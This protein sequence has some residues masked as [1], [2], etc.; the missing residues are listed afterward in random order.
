[1]EKKRTKT[2]NSILDQPE[3]LVER[4]LAQCEYYGN[5]IV[6]RIIAQ[7]KKNDQRRALALRWVFT[8]KRSSN[9]QTSWI[10]G[11]KTV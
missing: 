5:K 6:D 4:L 8:L 2:V 10:F 1:M 3:E 9:F 11:D 7:I